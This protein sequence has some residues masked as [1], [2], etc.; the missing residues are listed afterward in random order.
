[1]EGISVNSRSENREE[2]ERD[3][4]KENRAIRMTAA[5]IY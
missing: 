5:L 2:R 4:I 1:M 3:T